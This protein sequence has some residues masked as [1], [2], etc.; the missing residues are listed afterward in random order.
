MKDLE[1]D[2]IGNDFRIATTGTAG[3]SVGFGGRRRG[4]FGP[5]IFQSGRSLSRSRIRGGRV[6]GSAEAPISSSDWKHHQSGSHRHKIPMEKMLGSHTNSLSHINPNPWVNSKETW[7]LWSEWGNYREN[8]TKW[9]L[10]V[11]LR[12]LQKRRWWK[13]RPDQFYYYKSNVEFLICPS[14]F[15]LFPLLPSKNFN[16]LFLGAWKVNKLTWQVVSFEIV[17]LGWILKSRFRK[18]VLGLLSCIVLWSW[19]LTY[20]CFLCSVSWS[21]LSKACCS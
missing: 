10:N 13:I 16:S 15:I 1:R 19:N 12:E 2:K 8:W 9:K 6:D 18:S 14:I 21:C 20:Q 17:E 11:L 5:E 7:L 3:E 4:Y